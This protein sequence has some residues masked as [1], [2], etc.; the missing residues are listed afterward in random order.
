MSH[1]ALNAED[2]AW[3]NPED[4]P[5]EK[6]VKEAV[7]KSHKAVLES[8]MGG[9]MFEDSGDMKEDYLTRMR[10]RSKLPRSMAGAKRNNNEG[11][12]EKE[13]SSKRRRD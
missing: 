10:A 1:Y 6:S 12:A 2:V 8:L 13:P 4:A 9:K 7:K 5:S 3:Q 11:S